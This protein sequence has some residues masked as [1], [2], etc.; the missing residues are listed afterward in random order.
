MKSAIFSKHFKSVAM[1]S[2]V[3]VS[4]ISLTGCASFGPS[5]SENLAPLITC[6]KADVLITNLTVPM[7][8]Q[9]YMLLDGRICPMKKVTI[10]EYHPT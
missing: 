2:L 10:H 5:K 7:S 3:A 4:G 6:Q 8:Q 9:Q 1:I